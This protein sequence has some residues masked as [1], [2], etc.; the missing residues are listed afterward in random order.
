MSKTEPKPPEPVADE[1]AGKGGSYILDDETCRRTLVER[2]QPAPA[3]PT[4][5]EETKE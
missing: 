2:T 4:P 1:H 3:E 5:P